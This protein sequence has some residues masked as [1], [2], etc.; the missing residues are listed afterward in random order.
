MRKATV[1]AY[2]HRSPH[3]IGRDQTLAKAHEMM[4]KCGVRHL[5]VLEGGKL[6]GMVTLRDLHLIETLRDVDPE[7]VRVEEAMTPEVYVVSPDT[8]LDEAARTMAEHKY[9]SA[10][11]V[12]HGKVAGVFTTIDALGALAELVA[13]RRTT[14]PA[15]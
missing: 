8:P 2:M 1:G 7:E 3:T 10:V 11:V 9:G 13:E 6:A 5:P 14:H 12:D 4:R 15:G